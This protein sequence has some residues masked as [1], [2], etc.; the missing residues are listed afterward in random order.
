MRF[1]AMS[2]LDQSPDHV[3]PLSIDKPDVDQIAAHFRVLNRPGEVREVRILGHVPCSGFGSPS[4]ASGYFD[5]ADCLAVALRGIGSRH[6]TGIYITH[7]PVDPDLLARANNRLVRRPKQTTADADIIRLAH[8][9]ADFDPVR[10]SGISATDIELGQALARRDEYIQ[11]VRTELGWPEPVVSMMSG[12]GGQATWRIDLPVDSATIA[13]VQAVLEAS[14][15][16]FTTLAVSVDTALSNPSRV[17]KLSGT[18]AAKG[19]PLPHRPHRRAHSVFCPE[20]EVVSEGQL[21]ALVALVPDT[22]PPTR[23][24]NGRT[25]NVGTSAASYDVPVLLAT[26]GIG[27]RER[28]KGWGRVYELDHCLSSDDHL[29]GAAI[30]QFANGAVAYHCF[31]SRCTG[32]TWHDV[33]SR[34]AIRTPREEVARTN[35]AAKHG[36]ATSGSSVSAVITHQAPAPD[37]PVM[38]PLPAI[39]PP[40]PTMQEDMVPEPLRARVGDIA[41]LTK[42]PLEMV[43]VPMIAAA[44]AVVGRAVGLRPWRFDDFTAVPNLWGAVIARPGW[45]KSAAIK[46]A[47]R[48]LGLL[49]AA[50]RTAHEAQE[51]ENVAKREAIEAEIT[52]IKS[53]MREQAK[54]RRK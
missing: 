20:A 33:K 5:N 39:T 34:L 23:P 52:A 27:Y 10:K 40:V 8:L 50:S 53:T 43:A 6:A 44:G 35:D 37:W 42:L 41:D 18:V 26:A 47:F 1:V 9:T 31:H 19:D 45:L 2:I 32:V 51:E 16:L 7:N 21:R 54:E 22:P 17:V 29:D 28:D 49:A 24:T 36:N 12:N 14:S 15:A 46:E 11:F 48:P 3:L 30:Y 4:T 13:L 25:P 38:R